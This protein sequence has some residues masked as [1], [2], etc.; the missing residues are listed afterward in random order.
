[1]GRRVREYASGAIV[2]EYDVRRCIHAAECVRG[3]PTVFDPERRPWID[4]SRAESADDL[5]EVIERCPTGALHYRTP[6]GKRS[7][8]PDSENTVRVAPDGP[9]YLRGSLRLHLGDGQLVEETRVAL[10]RCGRSGNKPFCD[11]SHEEAGFRH[12]GKLA[13]ID[14]K[15]GETAGEPLEITARPDGPVLV[16]GPAAI[17]AADGERVACAAVAFCRCGHSGTKPFCDGT[18][19]R[20]GFTSD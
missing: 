4:P 12:D 18:H 17:L 3:L 16:S 1:M 19:K 10:C 5:A 11:N 15:I 13:D 9:L 7:E 8:R 20:V 6:D 2:V 14:L